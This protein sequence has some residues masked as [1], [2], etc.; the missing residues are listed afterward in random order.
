MQHVDCFGTCGDIDHTIGPG[1]VPYANLINA[2]ADGLHRLPVF[3]IKAALHE[4]QV[5]ASVPPR[6]I[7]KRPEIA[8][9]R[10]HEL[11]WFAGNLD[12]T[13]YT[14]IIYL[15]KYLYRLSVSRQTT[16]RSL[17]SREHPIVDWRK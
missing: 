10:T 14:E 12:H 1:G 13:D 3:R 7:G 9:A 6:F 4:I 11:Q 8:M 5:E 15:Y 2:R 17:P 16:R